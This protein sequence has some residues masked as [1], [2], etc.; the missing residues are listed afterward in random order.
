[1]RTLLL[2]SIPALWAQDADVDKWFALIQE[3]TFFRERGG[4]ADSLTAFRRALKIA[5]ELREREP[6]TLPSS[7]AHTGSLYLEWKRPA[8]ALAECQKGLPH[9]R[10]PMRKELAAVEAHLHQVCGLAHYR[11]RDDEAASRE[12]ALALDALRPYGKEIPKVFAQALV[13]AGAMDFFYGRP[14]EAES[15]FNEVI[16][17][18]TGAKHGDTPPLAFAFEG[19]AVLLAAKGAHTEAAELFEQSLAMQGRLFGTLHPRVG[20]TMTAYAKTLRA[21]KRNKEAKDYEAR[22]R[23]IE[24]RSGPDTSDQ[25]I[26]IHALKPKG[27]K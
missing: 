26:S 22:A 25:M 3:G 27:R 21:L 17:L 1:M 8:E 12:I 13:S 9:L 5:E 10:G 16:E 20:P 24:E 7:Y 2:L 15:R 18:N 11:L 4:F 19:R 6:L 14:A 23:A